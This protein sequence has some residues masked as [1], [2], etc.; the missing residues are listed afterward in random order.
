LTRSFAGWSPHGAHGRRPFWR[1]RPQGGAAHGGL[2]DDLGYDSIWIGGL[3]VRAVQFLTEIALHQAH[4]AHHGIANVF[5]RS[6]GLLAMSVATLDEISKAAPSG[7]RYEREAGDRGTGMP[8]REALTR[9][10]ETVGIY[11]A[12]WRGDA[13]SPEPAPCSTRAIS[14]SR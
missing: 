11:G 13:S 4:Q 1:L 7:A 6:A 12:L 8:Y 10:K 2:A 9:M 3:G 14:S 5:S